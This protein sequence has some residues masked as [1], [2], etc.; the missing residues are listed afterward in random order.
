MS[1]GKP[2]RRAE[3][4]KGG[5]V[6]WMERMK[7]GKQRLA[8]FAAVAVALTFGYHVIFGQNG[9]STFLQK[10]HELQSMD[11]QVKRLREENERLAGHV[12]RLKSDSDVIEQQARQELHYARPDEVIV[13]L[14]NESPASAAT[15]TKK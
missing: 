9:V 1:S 3:E 4:A 15:P 13:T 8:A 12:E 2:I 6:G 7:D 11:E 10:Q 5:F 14:P